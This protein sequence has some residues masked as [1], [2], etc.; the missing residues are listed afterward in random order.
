MTPYTI[1]MVTILWATGTPPVTTMSHWPT[2]EACMD[3]QAAWIAQD[4]G[5]KRQAHCMDYNKPDP[6]S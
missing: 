5:I 4:P 1:W 3:A 2:M 6:V